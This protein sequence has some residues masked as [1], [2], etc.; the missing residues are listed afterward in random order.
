MIMPRHPSENRNCA[1]IKEDVKREDVIDDKSNISFFTYFD[2]SHFENKSLPKLLEDN[3]PLFSKL[4]QKKNRF[5]ESLLSHLSTQN[6]AGKQSL[7]GQQRPE[8][9]FGAI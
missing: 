8:P 7:S 2:D 4:S 5:N 6:S 9:L 3:N 1:N